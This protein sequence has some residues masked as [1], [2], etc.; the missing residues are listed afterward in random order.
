MEGYSVLGTSG[1]AILDSEQIRGLQKV[2]V[3]DFPGMLDFIT[4]DFRRNY[5][6]NDISSKDVPIEKYVGIGDEPDYI[7]A[8][9]CIVEP[10]F[11]RQQTKTGIRSPK[12]E[13]YHLIINPRFGWEWKLGSNTINVL[14]TRMVTHYKGVLNALEMAMKGE[15]SNT[16][17]RYIPGAEDT[18]RKITK[19]QF[20]KA[21][22]NFVE[23]LNPDK[24]VVDE[25]R[26]SLF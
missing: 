23:N 3:K 5:L 20:A 22:E 21:K 8:E 17:T 11:M 13:T 1:Y 26:P 16:P 14:G 6:G 10:G 12:P 15:Y 2:F 7:L 24:E 4:Q 25:S 9:L 19:R 18:F